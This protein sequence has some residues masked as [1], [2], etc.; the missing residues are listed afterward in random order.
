MAPSDSQEAA[1][2]I[3]ATTP[4][5]GTAGARC[6][7]AAA[8]WAVIVM[9]AVVALVWANSVWAGS[10]ISIRKPRGNRVPKCGLRMTVDANWVDGAGY[11]PVR[12]ELTSASGPVMADRTIRVEI[13][14]NDWNGRTGDLYAASFIEIPEGTATAVETLSIPQS[15]VWYSL[16]VRVSE[17][18]E[19]IEELSTYGQDFDRRGDWTEAIPKALFVHH[20]APTPRERK[21]LIQQA[22]LGVQVVQTPPSMNDLPDLRAW[23]DVM[24]GAPP[25]IE[26]RFGPASVIQRLGLVDESTWIEML[27]PERVPD[28]WTDLTS[29]DLIMLSY[30]D[31]QMMKDRQPARFEAIR[32]FASAGSILC[33]WDVGE[34]FERLGDLERLLEIPQTEPGAGGEL[35][36]DWTAPDILDY[37]KRVLT[38]RDIMRNEG[39]VVEDDVEEIVGSVWE[40]LPDGTRVLRTLPELNLDETRTPFVFREM[41]LGTVVAIS[42]DNPFPGSTAFWHW[43]LHSVDENDWQSYRRLGLSLNRRNDGFWNF[44]IPGVGAAPVMAFRILITAFAIV[45]G[46][47]NYWLLRRWGR[48]HLLLV[49]VPAGALIVTSMLF[50]YAVVSDGLGVRA[51]V[52]SV[53]LLDQT[54]GRCVS[55]SRQSYYAGLAPSAGLVFPRESVVYPLYFSPEYEEEH[56]P[57]RRRLEWD[58][59]QRLE[60]GWLRSRIMTQMLVA[61]A[62]ETDIRLTV[63]PAD[64]SDSPPEITNDLGARIIEL[65]LRDEDGR[66]YTATD[67]AAGAVF[68]PT[69]TARSAAQETLRLTYHEND[70]RF[71]DG[72]GRHGYGGYGRR[73]YYGYYGMDDG[74]PDPV[75]TSSVLERNLMVAGCSQSDLDQRSYVAVVERTSAVP[76]GTDVKEEASYHVL[77]GRW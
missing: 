3:F 14:P 19:E 52:R 4:V 15:D 53:T 34:D 11:R 37:G 5:P 43:M 66:Y 49:T 31:L 64:S 2:S 76:V 47:V 16:S 25:R 27:P 68:R 56:G 30:D 20:A 48:L 42:S 58:D 7:S 6:R 55:W 28:S 44:L 70:L 77:S 36:G 26:P 13:S 50:L 71:P 46:P 38:F 75:V 23:R 32:T 72:F 22:K 9:C 62:G 41:D 12:I 57:R 29:L 1:L 69:S 60:K 65:L 17:D 61:H 54:R 45:I 39:Y 21:D 10:G 73:Y 74:L 40:N 51:R 33:V 59:R 24:R 8:R 35:P 67:V 63:K 18:G